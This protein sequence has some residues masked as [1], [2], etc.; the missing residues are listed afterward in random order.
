[1]FT[2]HLHSIAEETNQLLRQVLDRMTVHS[3]TEN[4]ADIARKG[5]AEIKITH[6]DFVFSPV[7]EGDEFHSLRLLNSKNWPNAPTKPPLWLS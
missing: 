6:Q 3:P 4:P 5:I 1:M 7:E 2:W